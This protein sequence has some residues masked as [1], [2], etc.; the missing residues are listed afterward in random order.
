MSA[1]R[2]AHLAAIE[3][4]RARWRA[5]ALGAVAA[6][7][8]GVL[9][10]HVVTPLPG[11]DDEYWPWALGL[12]AFPVT[13]ALILV[14]R[15]GNG[16]GRMLGVVAI[17]T[18]LIFLPWWY[19]VTFPRSPLSPYA[20]LVDELAPVVQ[21]SGMIALLHLFPTGRPRGAWGRRG[22]LALAAVT[23]TMVLLMAFG[24]GP[25]ALT[26]RP[27]P[28]GLGPPW[29]RDAAGLGL[30]ALLVLA[31]LGL[32]TLV[33]RRRDGGDEQ[34]A[35]LRW[36]LLAGVVALATMVS[37]DPLEQ[38]TQG[39]VAGRLAGWLIVVGLYWSLPVA[40]MV[41]VLRYRLYEIDRLVSRTVAYTLVAAV[42][43][44]V[45]AGGVFLL[46]ELL[47][48]EG[49]VAVAAS[50]LAVAALFNPLRRRIQRTVDR[51]FDRSRYDAQRLVEE[52]AVRLR[53]HVQV[54][55]LLPDVLGVVDDALRPASASIWLASRV[56]PPAVAVPGR[57]AP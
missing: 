4:G 16:V 3:P 54:G 26:G 53:D 52:L 7:V 15:P 19:A 22:L 28:L 45:Y 10:L 47:P 12:A 44:A 50:T 17:A 2:R 34:R 18:L 46:R 51:R 31:V 57:P 30:G 42:L 41:A 20:E 5:W 23:A 32:V 39:P 13:S 14:K 21:F 36:F 40:I 55:E 8:V 37:L 38:V 43:A 27:N 1:V 11:Q 29:F 9:V 33:L 56:A 24:P 35:Q 49:E 25:M 6:L 48:L